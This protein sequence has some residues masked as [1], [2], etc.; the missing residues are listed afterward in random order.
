VKI[1]L[2]GLFVTVCLASFTANWN[3]PFPP[4]RVIGNI[5]YVGT[6]YLSSYLIATNAGNILINPSYEESVPLISASVEKLG[7]HMKDVKII[8]ISHA[9]DDHCAGAA[10]M[11]ELTHAKLMVMDADVKEVEDGGASDFHYSDMRW[12]PVKVDQVLHD[13]SEVELGGVVLTA[14]KTPGHTKG[15]TTWSTRVGNRDVVIVGSPNVNEGYKLLYNAKYPEIVADYEKTFEVL[16][17]LRCDVFLGAHGAYYHM[18]DKYRR[19]MQGGVNPFID[20]GGYEGYVSDREVA[21]K[22]ELRRQSGR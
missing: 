13:G 18:E 3:E 22:K 9:H 14:H 16:K 15:C 6:N 1:F 8:L 21:F 7:Y 19:L 12:K 4:H 17:S 20:P 10:K 5:F 2:S 11:K